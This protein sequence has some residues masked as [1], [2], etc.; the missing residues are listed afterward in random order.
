MAVLYPT[1]ISVTFQNR[2][3]CSLLQPHLAVSSLISFIDDTAPPETLRQTLPL[4]SSPPKAAPRAKENS[5]V[6][7][8]DFSG[9]GAETLAKIA[10]EKF[11]SRA[12]LGES[13]AG[14]ANGLGAAAADEL[15]GGARE[16]LART[17]AVRKSDVGGVVGGAPVGQVSL[18]AGVSKPQ[19]GGLE[20]VW[21]AEF[22]DVVP[23]RYRLVSRFPQSLLGAARSYYQGFEAQHHF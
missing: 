15:G 13:P 11:A 3:T 10:A 1:L 14:G 8:L 19:K 17:A 12:V 16:E 9:D 5:V 21:R 6:R 23:C 2:H 22:V 18:P 4:P 7:G 20:E